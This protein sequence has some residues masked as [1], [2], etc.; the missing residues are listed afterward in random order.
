M[1]GAALGTP[2]GSPN[3]GPTGMTQAGMDSRSTNRN[4][5]RPEC[6]SKRARHEAGGHCGLDRPAGHAVRTSMSAA[7]MASVA[8]RLIRA[9][10]ALLEVAEDGARV[11][12]EI[13]RRLR[14]VAVVERE[15]LVDVVALELV[16]G[17]GQR[18]DRR[19]VI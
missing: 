6:S 15:D 18:Q 11:D 5:L 1:Y 17:L 10:F 8:E 12:A 9:A 3:S 2:A 7:F 13:A 19:Q 14:A 16:L 4:T